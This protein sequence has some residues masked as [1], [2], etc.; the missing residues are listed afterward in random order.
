MTERKTE[1]TPRNHLSDPRDRASGWGTFHG[2]DYHA[3]CSRNGLRGDGSG[4]RLHV[5]P[6]RV[7]VDTRS[8]DRGRNL[9][10]GP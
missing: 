6:T 8:H 1:R 4:L 5:A 7:A 9:G 3:F 2:L 10:D